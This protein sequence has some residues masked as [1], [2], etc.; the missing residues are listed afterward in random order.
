MDLNCPQKAGVWDITEVTLFVASKEIVECPQRRLVLCWFLVNVRNLQQASKPVLLCGRVNGL[1]VRSTSSHHWGDREMRSDDLSPYVKCQMVTQTLP[2]QNRSIQSG[3]LENPR[4]YMWR[5]QSAS[6]FL[7]VITVCVA[8]WGEVQLEAWIRSFCCVGA[9][10]YCRQRVIVSVC[11]EGSW[12]H[13]LYASSHFS[14][15]F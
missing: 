1:S 3:A 12:M 5:L 4:E 11:G 2:P 15:V 14:A 8:R 6:P 7:I 10:R 13:M 9:C